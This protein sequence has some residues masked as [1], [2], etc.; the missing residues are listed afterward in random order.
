MRSRVAV[1]GGLVSWLLLGATGLAL[2]RFWP[3]Y[4]AA[5]PTKAYTFAMM[6]ARL[7]VAVIASV[8]AGAMAAKM[9]RTGA[10]AAWW[11]GVILLGGSAPIHLVRV[12]ADYPAWYHFAYLLLIPVTGLSG[13]L[14]SGRSRRA[15]R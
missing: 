7:T 10:A 14:V 1:L 5:E 13:T 3:D 2:L 12:W 4:A 9:S 15:L 11:V 8:I 6:I